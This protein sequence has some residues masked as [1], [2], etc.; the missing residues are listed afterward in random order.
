MTE[1]APPACAIC[2]TADRQQLTDRAVQ[3][4][5]AQTYK[6]SHLLIY[7]TG[8]KPY[9]LE[10]LA[11]SRITIVC[12][13]H[14]MAGPIGALRNRANALVPPGTEILLHMDSDD[15]SGPYRIQDQVQSLI[16]SGKECV[17]YRIVLFWRTRSTEPDLRPIWDR[18]PQAWGYHNIQP[19]YCIGASFCYWRRVWERHK[20]REDLPGSERGMGEDKEWLN[21]V[22]SHGYRS[23][24]SAPN[25]GSDHSPL[26]VCEIHGGN[27]MTYSLEDESRGP[28]GWKREPSWD[29][30]LQ[31]VM[32]L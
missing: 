24:V 31:S 5:L 18:E 1:K 12:D 23:H 2:L 16:D 14:E 10:R 22:D 11:S 20:F 9:R 29:A 13:G 19:A 27:T 8:N 17:G 32:A 4:F 25:M 15:W 7:D 30:K 28:T 6:N 26:L 3:C 21:H